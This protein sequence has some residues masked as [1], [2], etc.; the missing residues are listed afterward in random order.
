MTHEMNRETL[1]N[2]ASTSLRTKLSPEVADIVTEVQYLL[3]S[4]NEYI[5]LI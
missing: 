2:V 3:R 4:Y 5:K 1:V